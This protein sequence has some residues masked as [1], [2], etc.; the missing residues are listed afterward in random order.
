MEVGQKGRKH[1]VG[2]KYSLDAGEMNGTNLMKN[3][4]W[5]GKTN[6]ILKKVVDND[7]DNDGVFDNDDDNDGVLISGG[8]DDPHHAINEC[9]L[10]KA[11][12]EMTKNWT[13]HG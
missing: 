13:L 2:V 3:I 11:L 6:N 12:P 9:E 4:D 7:D 1:T 5:I 10:R 8:I